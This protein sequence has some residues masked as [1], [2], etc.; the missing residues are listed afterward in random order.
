MF[1]WS[2]GHLSRIAGPGDGSP[3]GTTIF[4]ADAPTINATGQIAFPAQTGLGFGAFVYTGGHLA[5]VAVPGDSIPP[6]DTITPTDL[7]QINDLG[8]VSFGADLATGE[9]AIYLARPRD[10]QEAADVSA[11]PGTPVAGTPKD[12]NLLKKRHPRN[13][14]LEKS[15]SA[16]K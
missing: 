2:H 8:E 13:Y 10:R 4:S 15:P 9:T 5:K 6:N 1:L 3:D 7:P 12:R 11:I 14:A 16:K